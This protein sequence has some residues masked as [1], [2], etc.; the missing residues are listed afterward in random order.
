M[1]QNVSPGK[2]T[3]RSKRQTA[4]DSDE[5]TDDNTNML[6]LYFT[7]EGLDNFNEFSLNSSNGEIHFGMSQIIV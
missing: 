4:D 5:A 2:S 6:T 7:I 1:T 3:R